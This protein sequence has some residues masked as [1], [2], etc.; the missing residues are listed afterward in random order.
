MNKKNEQKEIDKGLKLLAK[1]SIVVFVGIFF[2]KIFNYAHRI[3]IA[4]YFGPEIYGLFSLALMV[5]GFFVAFSSLGLSDGLLRYIPFYR[6]KKQ[7]H[8]IRYVFKFSL[9]ISFFSTIISGIIL[10][11]LSEFISINFFHSTDLIIFLKIFSFLIPLSIFSYIFLNILKTFE[12]ISW[13]SFIWNILQNLVKLVILILLIVLGFKTSA[14]IF[15]YF[16]SILAIFLVSYLFCKYKLSEVFEKYK[17]DKKEKTKIM[18]EV[19]SYSWPIIFIGII[20]SFLY[21]ID[22]FA[23]GYFRGVSEVGFYNAAVPIAALLYIAP[24]LFIQLFFPLITK[25]YARKKFKIIKEL[26]KQVGKWIFILNL[27]V[28]LISIL[29]PGAIINLLFGSEYIIAENALRFLAIGMFFSSFFMISNNL[30]STIGKSKLILIDMTIVSIIN[31]IL[32]IILVPKYGINGAAF[33]TMI[34]LIILSLI[35]LFQTKHYLSIVPVRKKMFKI[36]IISLIPLSLLIFIKQFIIINLLSLILLSSLFFLLYLLLIF[37]T[38]CLDK[39]DFMILR[40]IKKRI[41]K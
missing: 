13:Y 9:A 33:S 19:F 6:G 7:I 31:I 14:I 3:I 37:I 23:I 41:I 25:E 12:K 15:S 5:L 21:W 34:S 16:L 8:K 10:F 18:K 22:S 20:S 30:I 27:P 1:S 26:S 2:A 29:F 36:L 38:K 39:N 17:L 11:F 28:F 35:F 24:T 4:R 32:N 40:A